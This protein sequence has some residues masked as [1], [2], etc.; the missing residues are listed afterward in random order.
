QDEARKE[1]K[2]CRCV[3]FHTSKVRSF[4]TQ[5]YLQVYVYVTLCHGSLQVSRK[6]PQFA[7][8]YDV[9]TVEDYYADRI[10]SPPFNH[11][12]QYVTSFIPDKKQIINEFSNI[13]DLERFTFERVDNM[14]E[15][16]FLPSESGFVLKSAEKKE[17]QPEERK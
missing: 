7:H 8:L 6:G 16:R 4:D 17:F 9:Y 5:T 11:I 13:W 2:L 15:S 1:L 12:E 3:V 14:I 10:T